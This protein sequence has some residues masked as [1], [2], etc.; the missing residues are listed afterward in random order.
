MALLVLYVIHVLQSVSSVFRL[1]EAITRV[2]VLAHEPIAI[3]PN[4]SIGENACY[5]FRAS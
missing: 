1:V 2:S 4:V 3:N 5:E